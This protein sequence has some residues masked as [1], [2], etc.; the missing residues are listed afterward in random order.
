VVA[1]EL[2]STVTLLGWQAGRLVGG[3]TH[4]TLPE[5]W[6]GENAAAEVAA[7]PDERFLYVANRGHDSVA[8]FAWEPAGGLAC[9]GH[10]AVGGAWPRHFAIDPSGQILLVANQGSD[11]VVSFRIDPPSGLLH[12]LGAGYRVRAPTCIAFA[13]G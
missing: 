4:S 10:S 7:T 13:S 5:R 6:E 11:E 3:P 2:A 1:A 12:R 8:V 9:V